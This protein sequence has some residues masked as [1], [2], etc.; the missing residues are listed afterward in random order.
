MPGT[1]VPL[2]T[3]AIQLR[4]TGWALIR[5]S[6][7]TAK[8]EG[9]DQTPH[10]LDRTHKTHKHK[11]QT[12]TQTHARLLPTHSGGVGQSLSL[13]WGS[14]TTA[15]S[16]SFVLLAC[17]GAGGG[18]GGA[19]TCAHCCVGVQLRPSC[20]Q[21]VGDRGRQDPTVVTVSL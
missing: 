11:L 16:C 20:L 15:W 6:A 4:L 18:W 14:P 2:T 8:A 1:L 13:G 10:T 3:L 21:G 9:S 7:S 17:K 19:V 12:Q 5:V